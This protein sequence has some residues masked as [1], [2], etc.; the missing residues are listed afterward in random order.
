M[1]RKFCVNAMSSLVVDHTEILSHFTR[2]EYHT[3][4]RRNEDWR[5]VWY[6][7]QN[8][9]PRKNYDFEMVNLTC[10]KQQNIYTDN[11]THY[12]IYS[13]ILLLSLD[14]PKTCEWFYCFRLSWLFIWKFLDLCKISSKDKFLWSF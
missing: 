1:F 5:M 9:D 4:P 6:R 7:D 14:I 8:S 3:Q 12:D 11:G 10:L 2:F 13:N